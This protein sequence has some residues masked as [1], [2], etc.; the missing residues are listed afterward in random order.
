MSFYTPYASDIPTECCMSVLIMVALMNTVMVD[1]NIIYR[2]YN[3]SAVVIEIAG[4]KTK[5]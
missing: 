5:L 3:V 1:F 2:V 4:L